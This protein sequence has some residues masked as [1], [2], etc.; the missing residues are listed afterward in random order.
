MPRDFFQKRKVIILLIL[1]LFAVGEGLYSSFAGAERGT[2]RNRYTDFV[3]SQYERLDDGEYEKLAVNYIEGIW[4]KQGE[5]YAV[6]GIMDR[7]AAA[8]FLKD[9]LGVNG[10]RIRF[11]ILK[12]IDY[13]T[14]SREAFPKQFKREAAVLDYADSG[15]EVEEIHIVVLTGHVTGRCSIVDWVRP[16]PVVRLHGKLQMI[17]RGMPEVY[18]LLHKEQWFKPLQF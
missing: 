17:I 9:D 2:V 12:A 1:C 7:E 18:Y 4:E 3:L 13:Y 8:S 16:V 6:S 14:L 5:E 11:V 10:W 15:E